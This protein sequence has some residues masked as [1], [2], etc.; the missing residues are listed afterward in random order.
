MDIFTCEGRV[1][2][3][4]LAPRIALLGESCVREA[5]GVSREGSG[6]CAA[7]EVLQIT[8]VPETAS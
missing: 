3:V 5:G 8:F 1:R 2:I 7:T 6:R 4:G